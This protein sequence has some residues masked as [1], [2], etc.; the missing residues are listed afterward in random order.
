MGNLGGGEILVILL[1]ALIVLGPTRLPEAARQVGR[2]AQELRRMSGT[3]QRELKAAVDQPIAET[4]AAIKGV[5]STVTGAVTPAKP[6]TTAKPATK[7]T[8]TKPATAAKPDS[9]GE[10]PPPDQP[11]STEA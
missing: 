5:E 9:N 7:A 1:V 4:R 10:A 8:T 11:D 6:A 2:A 3:F